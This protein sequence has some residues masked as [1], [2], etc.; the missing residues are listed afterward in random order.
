MKVAIDFLTNF[1]VGLGYISPILLLLLLFILAGAWSFHRVEGRP[2][3]EAVYMALITAITIGYG[4]MTPTRPVTRATA[5]LLGIVGVIFTGIMVSL[6]VYA[7]NIALGASALV[8]ST[9]G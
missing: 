9:A 5:V 2:F 4:D 3:W 1:I 8:H 6:A 7:A